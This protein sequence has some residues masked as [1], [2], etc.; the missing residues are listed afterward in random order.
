MSKYD[1][2]GKFLESQVGERLPMSFVDVETVLGFKLPASAHDY[3]A[4]WANEHTS[5]VQ[6]RAW[7]NAGYETEQVDLSARKLV[8]K[9]MAVSPPGQTPIGMSED[10]R[11]WPGPQ[12]VVARHPAIG[13]LKGMFTIEPGYDVAGSDP[14]IVAAF[15]DAVDRKA[16]L[17]EAGRS[18][19]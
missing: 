4:W 8:F 16:A 7:M 13:A 15:E 10:A 3:P 9:R 14:E 6:A 2:L 18:R 5:H 17:Y 19:K 12:A 1:V 11:A